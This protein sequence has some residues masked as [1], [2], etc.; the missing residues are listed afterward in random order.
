MTPNYELAATKALETL[1]EYNICSSP[2]DPLPIVKS[3]E[4]VIAMPFAD[5]AANAGVERSNLVPMFGVNQ[6]AVTFFIGVE[7]LKY[8]VAYNQYLP[9]DMIRRGLARELG[10][11]VLGHDGTRPADVRMAEAM[12]FARHLLFPRPLIHAL[13]EAGIPM[14]VEVVGS[15]TGCYE[16]CLAGLRK[17]P[18]V[19][20]S[21]E[22]NR[23]VR[24]MFADFVRNFTEFQTLLSPGDRTSIA[25][26]GTYMDYYE[27]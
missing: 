7:K 10:H 14:T 9:F 24:D 11:I 27:E 5:L 23:K 3:T 17:T 26:F 12:C 2:I 21:A 1:I 15:I 13:L 20:V 8:V 18:G 22:L 16:R 19:K 6:D 4:G 25:D